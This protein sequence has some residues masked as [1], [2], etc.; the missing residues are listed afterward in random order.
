MGGIDKQ[1]NTCFIHNK[2]SVHCALFYAAIRK[3][4]GGGADEVIVRKCQP[5]MRSC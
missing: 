3:R 4:G 1:A 5:S 2:I